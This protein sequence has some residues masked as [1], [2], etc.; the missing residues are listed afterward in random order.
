MVGHEHV[1]DLVDRA[2]IHRREIPVGLGLEE[3]RGRVVD[4]AGFRN[5]LGKRPE[6]AVFRLIDRVGR[7]HEEPDQVV[8]IDVVRADSQFVHRRGQV[9][10]PIGSRRW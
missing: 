4:G 10:R 8:W 7:R 2:V 3:M 1:A 5:L 6:P 9:R